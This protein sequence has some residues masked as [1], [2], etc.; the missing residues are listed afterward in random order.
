MVGSPCGDS[1]YVG[2]N[3]KA[4]SWWFQP[5]SKNMSQNGNLPQIRVN[6]KKIFEIWNHHL[7]NHFFW[8]AKKESVSE[9]RNFLETSLQ[10]TWTMS[11]IGINIT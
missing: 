8:V 10:Q 4:T 1:Y 6:I 9:P 3:P 11:T 7:D 2:V 5:T